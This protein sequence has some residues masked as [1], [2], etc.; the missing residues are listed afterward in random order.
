M[1]FRGTETVWVRSKRHLPS[2]M[3][4]TLVLM[5]KVSLSPALCHIIIHMS[6]HHTYVTSSYIHLPS[7][8]ALTLVLMWKVSSS[9]AEQ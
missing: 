5:W 4:L 6:H 2:S 7:S 1:K 9:P 3:A 8:M